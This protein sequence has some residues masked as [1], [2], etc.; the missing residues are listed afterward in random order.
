MNKNV[1]LIGDNKTICAYLEGLYVE[2]GFTAETLMISLKKIHR[3]LPQS[4]TI[5][6]GKR[7]VLVY[8]NEDLKCVTEVFGQ[9]DTA[10]VFVC[11]WDTHIAGRDH[12]P[13]AEC[14]I[15]ID[16]KKPRLDYVEIELSAACNLNCKGCFQFSNLS[17][18]EGFADF[19]VFLKDLVRLKELFWGVGE[20]RLLGGEPLSNPDFLMFVEAARTNFPDSDIRLVSNGLLI[21]KLSPEQLA[22]IKK[23]NCVINISNYP[24]TGKVLKAITGCL[25]KAGVPYS[26]SLPI[27]IFY[28]SLLPEPT[29]SPEKAFNN[30]IFTHCHALSQGKLAACSHQLYIGRLNAAFNLDYPTESPGEVFNIHH[31]DL[32]GWEIDA[33]I[34]APH[35]FC[36]YCNTGMVPY[37]WESGSEYC[38]KE[39]DWIVTPTPWNTM[40][41]PFVQR[42]LK[43]P[44]KRL[45][46][47]I[48]KPKNRR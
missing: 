23:Y 4:A 20:I 42:V 33:L 12:P 13:L 15:Q 43:M 26:I 14:V 36:R 1:L 29:K 8:K 46:H 41:I 28:K 6:K 40:I 25:K 3:L 2:H 44:A 47:F 10:G 31:T 32:N 39:S 18:E 22:Q 5:R 11:P 34:S 24:P 27:K 38:A 48:G 37:K 19:S 17:K 7:I 45:R 16:N 21:Q 9:A 35:N 30:C